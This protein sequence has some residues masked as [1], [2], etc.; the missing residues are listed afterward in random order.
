[1]NIIDYKLLQTSF[2]MFHSHFS[3]N[4]NNDDVEK[5]DRKYIDK[6]ICCYM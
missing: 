2:D 4:N 3:M 5:H 1:M 6:N